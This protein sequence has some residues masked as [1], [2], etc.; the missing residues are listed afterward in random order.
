MAAE[1]KNDP[2]LINT[3]VE[4]ALMREFTQLSEILKENKELLNI[5][6]KL[7]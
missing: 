3:L 6:V 2:E 7:Y 1:S 5:K 4:L